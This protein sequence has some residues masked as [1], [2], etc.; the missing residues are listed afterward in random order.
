MSRDHH[1]GLLVGW[2][3]RT[4]LRLGV[5]PDRIY[6]YLSWFYRDYLV[7]HFTEE[8]TLLFSILGDDHQEV[9]QAKSEHAKIHE[10]FRQEQ[11]TADQLTEFEQLLTA[12]IRFEER[13]LFNTIQE[14]ASDSELKALAHHLNDHTFNENTEDEFWLA[15]DTNE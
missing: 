7:L 14:H 11:V 15:S 9:Q 4:G 1:H 3:I 12:H 13:V 2:K 6:R 5:T 10:F 8:E